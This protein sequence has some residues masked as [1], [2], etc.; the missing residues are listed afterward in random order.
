M[1]ASINGR[2][3]NA[4]VKPVVPPS[5]RSEAVLM[6]STRPGRKPLMCL[7]VPTGVSGYQYAFVGEDTVSYCLSEEFARTT[8]E[9]TELSRCPIDSLEVNFNA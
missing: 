4:P 1:K 3:V 9:Y 8:A 7:R 6:R 5:S 2:D